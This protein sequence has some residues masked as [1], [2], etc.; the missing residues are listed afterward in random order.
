MD[1]GSIIK[2]G[3]ISFEGSGV[4]EQCGPLVKVRV[5]EPLSLASLQARPEF[6]LNCIN[7]LHA[8]FKHN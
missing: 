8:I 1:V 7:F 3:G 2:E 6:T 5:L 4:T